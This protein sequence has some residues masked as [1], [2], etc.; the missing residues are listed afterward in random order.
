MVSKSYWWIVV[1][2]LLVI[3]FFWTSILSAE[4]NEHYRVIT[5]NNLFRPLGWKLPDRTP[6]FELIATWISVDKEIKI[7]Y[8]RNIKSGKIDRLGIGS[9]LNSIVVVH[10]KHNS[11]EMKNGEVY[12]LPEIS[13]LKS[14]GRSRGSKRRSTTS[15]QRESSTK[16]GNKREGSDD[17]S[18]LQQ[19]QRSIQREWQNASPE[20]RNRMIEEF[21]KMYGSR[22]GR[23]RNRRNR[24]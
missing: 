22:S 16:E 13:F 9:N 4:Y 6:K 11:L 2:G 18:S 7:A 19:N 3:M 10:I 8:V 21:R 17:S 12:E 23:R 24:Q 15:V 20:K 5:T 14:T 1:I